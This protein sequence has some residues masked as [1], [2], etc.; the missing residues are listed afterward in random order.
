M[1]SFL[2]VFSG[3]RDSMKF[4]QS[5]S[6]L[7]DDDNNN[8]R[9]S[10]NLRIVSRKVGVFVITVPIDE[11]GLY[12]KQ[13]AFNS[14]LER[15]DGSIS[16][17]NF[18]EFLSK[19]KLLRM[20]N[21]KELDDTSS[22]SGLSNNEEFLL[23]TRREYLNYE[24]LNGAEI[25]GPS[26]SKIY[27][28][29]SH[30]PKVHTTPIY[31]VNWL[32]IHDDMRKV[33]VTLAQECAWLLAP[34]IYANKLINFYRQRIHNYIKH[35]DDAFSVMCRLGFPSEQVKLAL[36]LKANNYRQA[37]DW[38]IDNV[39]QDV[40]ADPSKS[41]RSSSISSNRRGSILSSSF[42]FATNTNECVDGLLEIVKFYSEK[43]EPVFEENIKQMIYIGFDVDEA[44]EALRVTR[45]NVG[46]ACAHLL[47]DKSPS[48]LELRNGISRTSEVYKKIV[49]EAKILLHLGSPQTFI[50]L[51][52]TLNKPSQSLG[53]DVFS[54]YGDLMHHLVHLYHDEKHTVAVNQFNNSKIPLSALSC[55]YAL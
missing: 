23:V 6:T 3:L 2:K 19:F 33:I 8:D 10:L 55:P 50:F 12:V 18:N 31:K 7:D 40:E 29:T 38:L 37:L 39:K 49:E 16:T 41:P 35:N 32:L 36:K 24:L 14:A 34:T 22:L 13:C 42:E 53:W 20:R 21:K 52:N 5:K 15:A 1:G 30:L 47:G 25:A 51:V 54:S 9:G 17:T 46:A 43:D 45:N 44:R 27:Q 4:W 28:K 48:V 26:D 11:I